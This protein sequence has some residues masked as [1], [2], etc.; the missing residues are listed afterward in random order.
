MADGTHLGKID[1]NLNFLHKA[2]EAQAKRMDEM[3]GQMA[4][5]S[6]RL[7]TVDTLLDVLS[8]AYSIDAGE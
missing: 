4:A 3:V 8:N 2:L 6:N 5:V 7:Q 1:E